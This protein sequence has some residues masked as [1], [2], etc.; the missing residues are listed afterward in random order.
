MHACSCSYSH[1]VKTSYVVKTVA[2]HDVHALIFSVN[3]TLSVYLC[4]H[5][6]TFRTEN[7][8]ERLSF[9]SALVY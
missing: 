3:V 8:S 5:A 2:A 9:N 1:T 6:V 4:F 7:V